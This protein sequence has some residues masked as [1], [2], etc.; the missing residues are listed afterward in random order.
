M[1]WA[2]I[3]TKFL[4]EALL[5]HVHM[6][7]DIDGIHDMMGDIQEQSEIGDEISGALSQPV[8]FDQDIDEVRVCVDVVCVY[9]YMYV[10]S[11]CT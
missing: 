6:C 3:L 11:E 1:V 8:G 5:V 9:M 7:R 4:Y 10:S 2:S